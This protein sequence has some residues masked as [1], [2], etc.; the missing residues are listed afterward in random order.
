MGNYQLLTICAPGGGFI[1]RN[2]SGAG[3]KNAI[4]GGN[5]VNGIIQIQRHAVAFFDT[6]LNERIGVLVG[7]FIQSAVVNLAIDLNTSDVLGQCLCV[8]FEKVVDEVHG[9][10]V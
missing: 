4:I 6:H 2:G 9:F 3:F 7:F 1:N 10:T 8:V 5:V